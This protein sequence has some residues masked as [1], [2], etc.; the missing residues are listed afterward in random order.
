MTSNKKLQQTLSPTSFLE[1]LITNG[2]IALTN[3]EETTLLPFFQI[4]PTLKYTNVK[5]IHNR[6]RVYHPP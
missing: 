5:V 4:K 3:R 1:K 2:S 6:F